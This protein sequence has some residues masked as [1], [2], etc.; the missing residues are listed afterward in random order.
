VKPLLLTYV[1]TYGGALVSLVRPYV[2]LLI[3]VGFA[4][5]TPEA[6]WPWAVPKGNYSRI[7]AVGLLVGWVMHGC[8]TWRFG[9][10]KP[11][12]LALLGLWGWSFVSAVFARNQ[13]LAWETVE[14]QSKIYLPC[15]VAVTLIDSLAKVKQLM[16][17][18]V[19]A[20]G[21]LA[22]EFNTTYY[23]AAMFIP[24]DWK[25]RGLDNNGLA[26]TMV[27]AI[28][29]AFFLALHANRWWQRLL[30]FGMV[31][32]MAHV[33]LFSMSRGGMVAM[34]A[35]GVVCLLLIPRT[36]K[37]YL[38]FALVLAVV[39]RL[40]GPRVIS[41]FD[42]SFKDESDRDMSAQSRVEQWYACL[43]AMKRHP[44]TGVGTRGW[45]Y[46]ATEFGASVGRE[47]HSTWLQ[48]GAELG[49]PGLGCLV[50][51][52]GVC[53]GRLFPLARE[54]HRVSDPWVRYL[55]R[56]VIASLA[57]FAVSSQFVT[58]DGV[59]MP[60][61]IAILGA[62]L[63]K[64]TGPAA[65]GRPADPTATPSPVAGAATGKKSAL[66]SPLYS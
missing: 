46:V 6:A 50:L 65:P 11:V 55:S 41:R 8:G 24:Q 28:G 45:R 38:F 12:V 23:K 36:W 48:V 5:V 56:M 18:I 19:L 42:S 60:Y 34:C 63:L 30:A 64:V 21:Y 27:T 2:G 62:G 66:V 53:V 17:V 9:R 40:A 39:L 32:L 37:H 3:Y 25:Y 58:V 59:E 52:Y 10:A 26:I 22:Y 35:T 33:V 31:G 51:F 47:A 29:L 4:I 61:Y 44:L 16:W 43:N 54:R 15:L 20:N 7:V 49:L 1:L 57:G 14:F 13:E